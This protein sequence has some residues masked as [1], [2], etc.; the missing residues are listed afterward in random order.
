MKSN[1]DSSKVT[2]RIRDYKLKDFLF[3]GQVLFV[4]IT[5][6]VFIY[7]YLVVKKYEF[8]CDFCV[9][10]LLFLMAYNNKKIY[11]REKFTGIYIV[12]GVLFV[13]SGIWGIFNG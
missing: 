4:I 6:G 12:F 11:K 8:L 1:T 7:T 13:I 3:L 10:F 2:T 5:I 9:S